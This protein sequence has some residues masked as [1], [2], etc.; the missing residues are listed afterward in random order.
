MTRSH[1]APAT[2]APATRSHELWFGKLL[3]LTAAL[4]FLLTAYASQAFAA[5]PVA[6][7]KLDSGLGDLPHYSQWADKTGKT[8]LR[9]ATTGEKLDSG[10]G[11]LPHYSKWADPTGK[12]PMPSAPV[13]QASLR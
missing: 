4:A 13:Q 7:Q 5:E 6:G 2:A 9:A 10:L 11:D 3:P 1:T 12:T 8:P